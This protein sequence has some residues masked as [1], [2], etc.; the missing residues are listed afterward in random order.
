MRERVLVVDDEKAMAAAFARMLDSAGYETQI[1]HDGIVAERMLAESTFDA[2]VVDLFMP[3][4]EGLETVREAHRL[5]PSM[6]IVVASGGLGDGDVELWLKMS[7]ALG[8][9]VALKK[10]VS[11]MV[12]LDAVRRAIAVATGMRPEEP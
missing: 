11:K 4:R 7:T 8:A 12:L 1:A 5:Y 2:V 10:P 3:E 6:G 9:A